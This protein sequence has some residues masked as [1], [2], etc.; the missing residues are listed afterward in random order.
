MLVKIKLLDFQRVKKTLED[1]GY[2]YH[3]TGLNEINS[4]LLD[5]P[6]R[7]CISLYTQDGKKQFCFCALIVKRSEKIIPRIIDFEVFLRRRKIENIRKSI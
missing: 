3:V 5:E 4:G 2:E 7:S 1:I 6:G